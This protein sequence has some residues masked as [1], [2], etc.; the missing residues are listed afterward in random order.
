MPLKT[1]PRPARRFF[2]AL[3]GLL[4]TATAAFAQAPEPVHT[5]AGELPVIL[6]APHGGLQAVPDC[7]VRSPAGSRF[8]TR[9]DA[10]TDRLTRGIADELKRLTGKAPYLV[11]ANFHRRYIDANRPVAEAYAAPGCAAAYDGYHAAIRR[12][13]DD[14]RMRFPHALLL[15]I[16]GQ[17]AYR[18]AILR[19]TRNGTTV[20]A[21][22]ARAG[23]P[24]LTGPDSVFGRFAMMG[25]AIVPDNDTD[26][27]DRVEAPDYSG[28]HTVNRY[29]SH[30]PDGIDAIQL[31]FGLDL[32]D[33]AL[34]DKTARDTAQAIAVFYRRFLE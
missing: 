9:S 27:L 19:G 13:I 32:R 33:V 16:H 7:P 1:T 28:G 23:A 12:H 25:Y 22:L 31:E 10:R 15:D 34:I 11:I 21:L 3:P 4:F 6:T 29:G 26:P 2:S 18:D 8:V 14:I 20:R 30:R 17:A 5:A 24:S